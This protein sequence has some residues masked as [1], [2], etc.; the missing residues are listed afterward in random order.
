[1]SEAAFSQLFD[2]QQNIRPEFLEVVAC[3]LCGSQRQEIWGRKDGWSIVQCSSC[4]LVFVN[5]RLNEAGMRLVYS[6]DYFQLQYDNEDTRKRLAMYRI[7]ILDLERTIRGGRFLDVGAGRGDFLVAL[8]FH[9]EKFGCEVNEVAVRYAKDHHR[10]ALT[11]TAFTEAGYP[12]SF[13]DCVS[14][15]GV[16]EH[17]PDPASDLREAFRVLKPGGIVSLNTP[18]IDSLCARIYREN[19]RL[20]DPRFHIYYFSTR[21]MTRLLEQVGFRVIREAYFYLDTPYANPQADLKAIVNDLHLMETQL[22]YRPQSPA[23]FEN[24]LNI[25]AEKP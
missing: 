18:N 14:L 20:V 17:V 19:F 15:R 6:E 24:V 4:G 21:T 3:N 16:I 8:G 2:S 1:M 12:G 7:E 5:P 11:P 25:Y 10:L 13:F 9:W 22:G 23:F